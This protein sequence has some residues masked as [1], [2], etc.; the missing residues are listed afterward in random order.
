MD[1]LHRDNKKGIAVLALLIFLLLFS[2]SITGCAKSAYLETR[3]SDTANQVSPGYSGSSDSNIDGESAKSSLDYDKMAQAVP[4]QE[5][6]VIQNAVMA[7]VVRDVSQ[8]MD[9]I[10]TIGQ[11]NQGYT[12]SSNLSRGDDWVRGEVNLK[13]PSARLNSVMDEIAALGEIK[14]KNI[15]TQDVSEEYYDSQA[16]LTVLK[17]KEERLLAL[18]DQAKTIEEIIS[19][20]NEL[21][22]ARSD[23]E[24]LQGRLNY[25]ENSTSYSSI[26]VSLSQTTAEKLEVPEGILGKAV[27]GFIDSANG[28]ASFLSGFFIFLIA[29]IPWAILITLVILV[30]RALKRKYNWGFK[31]HK[32]PAAVPSVTEELN[33]RE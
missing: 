15:S 24:V 17:K 7:L 20:E 30:L 10:I 27:Q 14:D 25:L 16:R 32:K 12:V 9:D 6:K 21:T 29:F 2:T 22:R 3:Q 13:V 31:R 11:D 4:A 19:V 18:I 1:Y 5:R 28:V 33:K 26:S 8:I 23:I